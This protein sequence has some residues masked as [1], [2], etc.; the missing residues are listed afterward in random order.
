MLENTGK[1][2][3]MLGKYWEVLENTWKCWKILGNVRK[4]WEMLGN[5]GKG[6][7][8]SEAYTRYRRGAAE[9]SEAANASIHIS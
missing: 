6:Q 4:Y 1:C 7:G 3:E 2:W 8:A 9:R 5:P